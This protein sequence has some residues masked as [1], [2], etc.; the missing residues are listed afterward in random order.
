MI[1][2]ILPG[3]AAID[4]GAEKLFVAVAGEPVKSFGTFTTEAEGNR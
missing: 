3:F 1:D 4:I 2:T